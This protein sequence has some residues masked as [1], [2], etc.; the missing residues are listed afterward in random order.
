MIRTTNENMKK[1]VVLI[2]VVLF[3]CFVSAQTKTDS[4]VSLSLDKI[5]QVNQGESYVTFPFDIGNLEPLLFEANVSPNF[6]IRERKDSR[7][8][9]V[10]TSQI[11]IRMFDEYSYP[12]KTPSYIP[13]I[14]FYFVIYIDFR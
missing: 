11:I 6:K 7:L 3:N 5:A 9:A 4:I 14:V 10:L 13:Q 8:M 1:L 2:L 12:V